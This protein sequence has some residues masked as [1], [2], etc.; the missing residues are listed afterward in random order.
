MKTLLAALVAASMLF[1]AAEANACPPVQLRQNLSSNYCAPQQLQ[2]EVQAP[3]VYYQPQV[4]AL[5]VG[6]A[7]YCAPQQLNLQVR[8]R[9]RGQFFQRFRGQRANVRVN[10]NA[11]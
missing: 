1:V 2:L 5:E 6:A 10:V 8:H 3:Q 4:L 11:Y 7:N 9:Q